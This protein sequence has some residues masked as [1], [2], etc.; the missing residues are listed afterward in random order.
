[1]PIGYRINY[2]LNC[3]NTGSIICVLFFKDLQEESEEKSENE[4]ESDPINLSSAK[5]SAAK[6]KEIFAQYFDN[7]C[8]LCS[9]ELK[10]L[11]HALP[12]YK[13]E[14]KIEGYVKCCQLKFK[15]EKLVNDHLQFHINPEIFK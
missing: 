8:D 13:R 7:T 3:L 1:M 11:R 4:S 5:I 15:S 9:T 14:H 6:R 12:H 2:Q 10:S